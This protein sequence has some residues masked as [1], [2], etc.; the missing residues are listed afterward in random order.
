MGKWISPDHPTIDTDVEFPISWNL[1]T[2]VK[3]NPYNSVDPNGQ[4]FQTT[5]IDRMKEMAGPDASMIV[6]NDNNGEIDNFSPTPEQIAN[7][8][9]SPEFNNHVS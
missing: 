4:T 9:K 8:P 7:N 2:Y 3:L 6:D 1:Y 5:N